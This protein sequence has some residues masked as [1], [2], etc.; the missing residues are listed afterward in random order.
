MPCDLT[1]GRTEPCKDSLGGLKTAYFLDYIKDPFTVTDGAATAINEFIT[2]VFQYDLRS[3]TNTDASETPA[4]DR[5]NGTSVFNQT[6][7]VRLKKQDAATSNE[8]KLIARARPIIV[9]VDRNNVHKV[10]G[11]SEGMDLT[12]GNI[13]SGAAK[14]DF[15]GY[16]LTFTSIEGEP[17]AILNS[18]TVTALEALISGSLINP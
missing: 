7:N 1:T 9:T 2:E 13:Q 6:V 14:A 3:D 11:F 17:G 12:G 10:F 15:N 18:A 4:S 8:I 5:N 16:D